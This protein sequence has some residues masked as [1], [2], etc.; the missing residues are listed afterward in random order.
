[1]NI[2]SKLQLV[3]IFIV[4]SMINSHAQNEETQALVKELQSNVE[5]FEFIEINA[6]NQPVDFDLK[7]GESVV[8]LPDNSQLDGFRF[9][10]PEGVD[11]Y[12]F[13]WYFN[14]LDDWANW[15]L[16]PVEG[17]F[18]QNFTSWLNAVKLYKKFDRSGEKERSRILQ[19]LSSG[20]L[21][22]GKE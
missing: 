21:K 4:C 15:Y 22:E 20:Y 2:F 10:A 14:A 16:C 5:K 11:K 12:D 8:T 3:T 9:K 6:V 17:E 13:V 7:L 18:E 19:S 1:M